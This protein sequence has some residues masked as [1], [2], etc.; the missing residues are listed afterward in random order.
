VA[1]F[2]KAAGDTT[3]RFDSSANRLLLSLGET[4]TIDFY[5]SGPRGE[6]LFVGAVDSDMV[7]VTE[8]P[9]MSGSAYTKYEMRA[10][11]S[12]NTTIEA[13]LFLQ[14]PANEATRQIMWASMP[15]YASLTVSVL[16]SEY[17]QGG[18]TSWGQLKYGSTNPKWAKVHWTNMAMSGCGPTSLAM[19]MDYLMRVDAS[20]AGPMSVAGVTP[21]ETMSYT[22]QHGRKADALGVPAG[23][24]GPTMI[25]NLDKY[26]PGYEGRPV[27]GPDDAE[28][29]LRA[30]NPLVFVCH[31]CT[32]FKYDQGK[33]SSHKWPGHFMVLLGVEHDGQT[34]WISDP[35]KRRDKYISRSELRHTQIWH[36]YRR[37]GMSQ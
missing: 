12:G 27:A 26:W 16:G 5:G 6:S 17:T 7:A 21:K 13:R 32:T 8:R 2:Q 35:S 22:S 14:T 34:F 28:R 9:L 37:P 11:R 36:V 1:S 31:N 30:G 4:A 18:K 23:T 29:L 3:T 20:S 19:V 10:L 25:A 15:L 33:R 24:H